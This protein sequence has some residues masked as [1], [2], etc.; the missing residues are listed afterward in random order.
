MRTSET[1]PIQLDGLPVGAGRL[2]LTLCPG[3]KGDSLVGAPWDRDL[4]T[5]VARIAAEGVD[6]VVSLIEPDEATDLSVPDLGPRIEAAG[7]T[8][9][10]FPIRDG[11]VP[12]DRAAFEALAD[13]VSDLLDAGRHVVVHCKGGLGRAGTFASTVLVRRGVPPDEAIRQVRAAR[14]GAVENRTQERWIA[15]TRPAP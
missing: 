3:K 12:G 2:S 13:R 1:H 5:D 8:W 6:A 15:A 11:G 7:L 10:S 14:T 9:L 4:A